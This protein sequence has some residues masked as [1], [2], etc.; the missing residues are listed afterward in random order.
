MQRMVVNHANRFDLLREAF[1]VPLKKHED[2][3]DEIKGKI[4][5]MAENFSADITVK[6]TVQYV[7]TNVYM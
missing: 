6:G 1:G 4:L 2:I 7:P 5:D 3:Q